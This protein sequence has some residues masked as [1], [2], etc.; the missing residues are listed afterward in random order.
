MTS[1][2]G[3]GTGLFF[4]IAGVLLFIASFVVPIGWPM[5]ATLLVLWLGPWIISF[6]FAYSKSASTS[7]PLLS[8]D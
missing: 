4:E 5:L 7:E 2:F 8:G 6:A 1:F 3:C